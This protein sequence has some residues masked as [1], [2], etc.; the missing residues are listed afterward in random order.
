MSSKLL[1]DSFTFEGYFW[2]IM[3]FYVDSFFFF[4]QDFKNFTALS[5]LYNF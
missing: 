1:S 3:K 2:L 5:S 4:S